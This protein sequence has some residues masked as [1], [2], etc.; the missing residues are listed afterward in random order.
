MA[1]ALKKEKKRRESDIDAKTSTAYL[2]GAEVGWRAGHV[3]GW[4]DAAQANF[5]AGYR[6]GLYDAAEIT[7]AYKYAVIDHA[8]PNHTVVIKANDLDK[9][10]SKFPED[11]ARYHLLR[12]SSYD[13]PKT[14]TQS[15]VPQLH[16]SNRP[17]AFNH[18]DMNLD[19]INMD[20]LRSA[21]R[22]STILE[23]RTVGYAPVIKKDSYGTWTPGRSDK[24]VNR[25]DTDSLSNILWLIGRKEA[26]PIYAYRMPQEPVMINDA[27]SE[28]KHRK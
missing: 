13:K 25:A 4:N 22:K 17:P 11:D 9:L 7:L 23:G 12:R 14:K 5:G 24:T 21:G 1:S 19:L 18:T 6:S 16:P 20:K 10:E 8:D 2:V 27:I 3:E 28:H 26:A 15:R